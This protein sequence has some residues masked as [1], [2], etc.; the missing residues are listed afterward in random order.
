MNAHS[1]QDKNVEGAIDSCDEKPAP[2]IGMRESAGPR[3]FAARSKTQVSKRQIAEMQVYKLKRE[4]EVNECPLPLRRFG[5][6]H[7]NDGSK[8]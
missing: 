3:G 8:H 7:I 4:V 5:K 2:E 6:H 1:I